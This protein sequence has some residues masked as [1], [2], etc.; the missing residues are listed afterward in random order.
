[1]N[2]EQT[3]RD[4]LPQIPH[5]SLATVSGN[6]PWVCEVHFAYD[7]SLNLYFRSL[8]SRRHCRE[9]AANPNVAGNIVTQH[10]L[11][12]APR[13]VSFEGTAKQL[14]GGDEEATAFEC[15]SER[16]G[17]PAK[18]MEEAKREHHF[19]KLSVNKYY[20]FD[21]RD[22]KPSQKFELAWNGGHESQK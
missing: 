10:P 14:T 8:P 1:M 18:V 16:L 19:Y 15:L 3:I 13:C 2:I 9:I 5:M 22:T 11:N 6:A 20:L 17:I 12:L 4:Y 21:A 7:D